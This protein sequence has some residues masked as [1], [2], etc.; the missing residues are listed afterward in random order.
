MVPSGRA[1]VNEMLQKSL[2]QPLGHE[3]AGEEMGKFG[4]GTGPM[5]LGHVINHP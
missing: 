3:I 5:E 4:H 1:A 2:S